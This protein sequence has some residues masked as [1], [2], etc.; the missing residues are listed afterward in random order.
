MARETT[1]YSMDSNA[2]SDVL[3]GREDIILR[4][5]A[6]IL[7][8]SRVAICSIVHYE[9]VRGLKAADSFRRLRE[10]YELYES[11]PHLFLDRDNM[12]AVEKASEIYA[13]LH[14]GQTIEDNDI[15]IAAIAMANDCVLVTDNM[16][17]F[18]RIP[19]LRLVNWRG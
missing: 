9:I 4:M 5:K 2:V 7:D 18:G 1:N 12:K 8:G 15:L 11:L 16:K 17:H 10:F 19:G 3:R 13:R 14:R 6:A